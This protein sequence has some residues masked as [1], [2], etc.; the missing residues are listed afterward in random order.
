MIF[1]INTRDSKLKKEKK[2]WEKEIKGKLALVLPCIQE[3]DPPKEMRD[4]IKNKF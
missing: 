2:N 3:E 1:E 4:I